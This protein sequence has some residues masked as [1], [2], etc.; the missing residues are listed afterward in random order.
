MT[1][2]EQVT[3]PLIGRHAA[4]QQAIDGSDLESGVV[5]RILERIDTESIRCPARIAL[6][7]HSGE[8]GRPN[9]GDRNLFVEECQLV[10]PSFF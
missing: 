4:A 5:Q 6:F 3:D 9:A 2:T 1:Q 7:V 10:Q 8:I